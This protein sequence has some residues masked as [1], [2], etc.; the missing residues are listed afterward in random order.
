MGD[1]MK[2]FKKNIPILIIMVVIGFIICLGTFET[3]DKYQY[4][5]SIDYQVKMQ[6]DGSMQVIETWDI[7][8]KNTNTLFK[9]FNLDRYKYGSITNVEVR[10]LKTGRAFDKIYEE[11]YHVTKD[12]YYSLPI[13]H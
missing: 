4:L 10:D 6:T 9:T 3:P 5:N 7:D 1:N 12:C 2:F 11:M 13:T 8:V